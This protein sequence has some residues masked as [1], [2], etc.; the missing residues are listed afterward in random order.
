MLSKGNKHTQGRG[1]LRYTCDPGL[2]WRFQGGASAA[3]YYF[4]HYMS[5]HICPGEF[6]ILH[7]RL[8]NFWEGNCSFGFLLIV[9]WLWC[10][11]FKCVLLSL[12]CLGQKVVGNCID[13]W[14]QSSFQFDSIGQLGLISDPHRNQIKHRLCITGR[15]EKLSYLLL[16]VYLSEMF[17]FRMCD[18]LIY[19]WHAIITGIS[20]KP[21]QISLQ[22]M[23][24]EMSH[25][26]RISTVCHSITD[27]LSETPTCISEHFQIT[28]T[29]EWKG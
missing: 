5:L 2:K 13:S 16:F 27:F 21:F 28:E 29:E 17:S 6:L 23:K 7:N 9:L 14:S 8:A 26:I 11:C 3:G 25:L 18:K 15:A 1:L 4:C 20:C 24:I 19:L 22:T 12:W 10:R